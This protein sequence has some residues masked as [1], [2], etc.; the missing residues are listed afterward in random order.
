MMQ[1]GHDK[2]FA[3]DKPTSQSDG[4]G[5]QENGWQEVFQ[6]RG[7]ML[8]RRGGEEVIAARLK[9]VQPVVITIREVDQVVE[10]LPEYRARDLDTG[11]TYNITSLVIAE[12]RR[13]LEIT[14]THGVA[15]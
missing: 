11:K 15:I 6:C 8:V 9:G 12:N 13:D 2:A 1:R 3:F 14:A 5:G 7:R 4:Q 10:L